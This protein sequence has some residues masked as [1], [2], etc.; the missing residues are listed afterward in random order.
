MRLGGIAS[1]KVLVDL[2][3]RGEFDRALAEGRIVRNARGRYSLPFADDAQKVA[4]GL[5]ATVSHRSAAGYWGWEMKVVPPQPQVIVPRSAPSPRQDD[6]ALTS[7][8][9]T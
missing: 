8:G 1:R 4:N 5:S 2:T 6:E 7:R 3:S 9:Q